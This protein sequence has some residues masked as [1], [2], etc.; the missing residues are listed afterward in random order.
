MNGDPRPKTRAEER[1]DAIT[2]P[3]RSELLEQLTDAEAA[4]AKTREQADEN[5]RHWQRT[6]ADFSNYKRRTEE[7][8]AAMGLM[9]NAV[10][11]GRLLAVIDDFDRALES[12][13][14][15]IHE[16]W[17]DG[18]RLVERKLQALLEAEGRE[19]DRSHR[20]ALRSQSARGGR[21]R[22]D[23]RIPRQHRHR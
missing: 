15:D 19:A 6:A 11:L 16:G 5:L 23:H 12:V 9:A 22:G 14:E 4:L 10:L 20:S 1:A 8:R 18:I 3:S 17:L 2:T 13:P 21:P 7:E